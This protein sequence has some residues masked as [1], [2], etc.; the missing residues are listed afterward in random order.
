MASTIEISAAL[1]SQI[2]AACP[3][4][5]YTIGVLSDKTTWVLRPPATA[6]AAQIT[7]G[8]N[9]LQTFDPVA[10]AAT[11][12][13]ANANTAALDAAFVSDANRQDIVSKLQNATPTQILNWVNTNVTDLTSAKLVIAK[14]LLLVA[15]TIKT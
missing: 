8:N 6:T 13:T 11:I 3:G 4:A 12:D 10:T 1:N 15:R 2:Q 7:A 9:V 14:I 5:D